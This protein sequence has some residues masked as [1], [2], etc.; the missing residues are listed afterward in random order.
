MALTAQKRAS[1]LGTRANISSFHFRAASLRVIVLVI[2]IMQSATRIWCLYFR[3]Y[4]SYYCDC[5]VRN[6]GVFTDHVSRKDRAIG[7]VSRTRS[8]CL[9]VLPFLSTLSNRLTFELELYVYGTTGHDPI[10]HA[11]W[12][13]QGHIINQGQGL[14]LELNIE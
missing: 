9:S 6:L 4:Y 3:S 13:S 7:I 1:H 5:I 10:T 12:K 14:K 8:V 2:F 11:G